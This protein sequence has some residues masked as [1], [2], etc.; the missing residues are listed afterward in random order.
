MHTIFQKYRC[1]WKDVRRN[2]NRAASHVIVKVSYSIHSS[3]FDDH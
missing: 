1:G 2:D 3:S